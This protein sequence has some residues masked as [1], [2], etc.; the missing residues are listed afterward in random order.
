MHFN[1]YNL[2]TFIDDFDENKILNLSFNCNVIIRNYKKKIRYD[3][4]IKLKKLCKKNR[5]KL[6][7][8]N[9][10]KLA[11]N[12]NLDGVYIPSFNKSLNLNNFKNK[13]NFEVLGSA[14]TIPEIKIKER[15]GVDLIF[16]S[17]LFLT[18]NYKK[19]G[20]NKIQF[21]VKSNE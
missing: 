17:P 15:Q 9:D 8:A 10:T 6:Y 13:K 2:Y 19:I 21:N 11:L 4:L 12:A 18:K 16:I 5:I 20:Y 3:T 14:H 7:L 1:R